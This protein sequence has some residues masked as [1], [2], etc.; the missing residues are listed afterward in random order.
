MIV[1]LFVALLTWYFQIKLDW[2]SFRL[3]LT[4]GGAIHMSSCAHQCYKGTRL[5]YAYRNANGFVVFLILSQLCF[6]SHRCPHKDPLLL[7][8]SSFSLILHCLC[9]FWILPHCF[10]VGFF[11][12]RIFQQQQKK[13]L[14][15]NDC[16]ALVHELALRI[17]NG[18]HSIFT[19]LLRQ[20]YTTF[21]DVLLFPNFSSSIF[22]CESSMYCKLSECSNM[23]KSPRCL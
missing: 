16:G 8:G 19:V 6:Y 10:L 7:L 23:F 12:R 9:L 20:V 5:Y 17:L 11:L 1:L 2:T 21:F 15:N 14:K 22:R 3:H 18:R 13:D 4:V